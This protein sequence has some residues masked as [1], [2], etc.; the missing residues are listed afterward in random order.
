MACQKA[1][2]WNV[3]GEHTSEGFSWLCEQ[4]LGKVWQREWTGQTESGQSF[5]AVAVADNRYHTVVS[6]SRH[7]VLSDRTSLVKRLTTEVADKESAR[8]L[9]DE[10]PP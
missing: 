1:Y 4:M 5:T 6:L 9:L 2:F 10:L 8:A 3:A 7:N